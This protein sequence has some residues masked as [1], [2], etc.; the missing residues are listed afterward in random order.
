MA[1]STK[2]QDETQSKNALIKLVKQLIPGKH[3]TIPL[4]LPVAQ[5]LGGD[6]ESAIIFSQCMYWSERTEDPDGWFYKPYEEWYEET[7]IKERTCRDRIKKLESKGWIQTMIWHVRNVPKLHVRVLPDDFIEDLVESQ[8]AIEHEK[9]V[10]AK[11]KDEDLRKRRQKRRESS[12]PCASSIRQNL[13]DTVGNSCRI[14]AAEFAGSIDTKTTS[15]NYSTEITEYTTSVSGENAVI[16]E[17]RL[18]GNVAKKEAKPTGVV[19]PENKQDKGRRET[20]AT[21]TETDPYAKPWNKRD[22]LREDAHGYAVLPKADKHS[23]LR[24]TT[25]RL[26][27]YI[28][29]HEVDSEFEITLPPPGQQ[30]CWVISKS[31]TGDREDEA[32]DPLRLLRS[33]NEVSGTIDFNQMLNDCWQASVEFWEQPNALRLS[34]TTPWPILFEDLLEDYDVEILDYDP[35]EWS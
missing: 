8:A 12:N 13:P 10:R 19:S 27:Q 9:E 2:S 1:K 28:L 34:K 21:Q 35:D 15:R 7:T 3:N 4:S 32:L 20:H 14:E 31:N 5:A 11:K 30:L 25:V 26:A 29:H 33:V 22:R 6:L 17:S 18:E 23:K 16:G 24:K